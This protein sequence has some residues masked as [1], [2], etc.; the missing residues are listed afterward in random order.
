M[1]IATAP[2]RF[3]GSCGSE[4]DPVGRCVVDLRATGVE[5]PGWRVDVETPFGH[6]AIGVLLAPSDERWRARIITFPKALW[7]VPGSRETL[8]FV[9]E[10]KQEAEARAI[11]FIERHV[12]AKRMMRGAQQ[13]A[14]AAPTAVAARTGFVAAQRKLRAIPVRFG[15]DRVMKRGMTLNVSAEGMFISVPAPEDPGRSLIIQIEVHGHT[16]P[17]HG[18]VMWNRK[19][20]EADRPVGMGIRLSD[21][22]ALYQAYVASLP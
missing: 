21:P 4:H 7:T 20:A 11:A 3:C 8:K 18:F 1:G 15:F 22:P 17:M 6:E 10:T 19:R 9:G 12:R 14:A 5:V 2:Q 13:A 16:L